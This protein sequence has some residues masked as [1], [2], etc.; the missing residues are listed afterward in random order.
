MPFHA[1]EGALRYW[2][3]PVRARYGKRRDHHRHAFACMNHVQ[4]GSFLCFL[5]ILKPWPV[6]AVP[7]YHF[8]PHG[9]RPNPQAML[10]VQGPVDHHFLHGLRVMGNPYDFV[11][12]SLKMPVFSGFDFRRIFSG[13]LLY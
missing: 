4:K 6:I 13:E 12:I 7:V 5:N 3:A 1:F 10:S 2:A 9:S 8:L 11:V